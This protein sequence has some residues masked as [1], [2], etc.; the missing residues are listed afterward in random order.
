M[1][2]MVENPTNLLGYFAD[3]EFASRD[4]RKRR[5]IPPVHAAVNPLLGLNDQSGLRRSR[6]SGLS[7]KRS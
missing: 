1:V 4:V 6:G 3:C 2:G 5:A 7:G